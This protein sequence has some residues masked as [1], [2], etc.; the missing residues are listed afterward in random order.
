LAA[1]GPSPDEP[2]V[3]AIP[4]NGRIVRVRLHPLAGL[5]LE[6]EALLRAFLESAPETHGSCGNS[7]RVPR[8]PGTWRREARSASR[9]ARFVSPSSG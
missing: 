1:L 7:Q 8:R 2:L 6:A 3:N 9:R 5:G 4:S